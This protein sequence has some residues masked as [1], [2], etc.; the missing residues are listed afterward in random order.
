MIEHLK[1]IYNALKNHP[2]INEITHENAISYY[3]IYRQIFGIIYGK[4]GKEYEIGFDKTYKIP[5][6]ALLTI[7]SHDISLMY[8]QF[9]CKTDKDIERFESLKEIHHTYMME[10]LEVLGSLFDKNI[11]REYINV[12][13]DKRFKDGWKWRS[14]LYKLSEIE[15]GI[16][17]GVNCIRESQWD[18]VIEKYKNIIEEEKKHNNE[19]VA[20]C[21]QEEL[22][23]L[24]N[25]T[26]K[27]H[28]CISDEEY[29]KY[30]EEFN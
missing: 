9:C 13:Y 23:D 3:N 6:L 17:K 7:D 1:E 27:Y 11:K 21:Y 19:H 12:W 30:K 8:T 28:I 22:D 18:N 16:W 29:I 14:F 2:Y 5:Q 15:P 26:N 24:I 25:K 10:L 4:L 20:K